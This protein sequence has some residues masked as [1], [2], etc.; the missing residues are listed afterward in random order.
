MRFA[1]LLLLTFA[2]ASVLV[3]NAFDPNSNMPA[4]FWLC[5]S[6]IYNGDSALHGPYDACVKKG[7]HF[8]GCLKDIEGF[9]KC[10]TF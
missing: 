5:I 9:A 3:V 7:E 1:I 10:F 4:T 8:V 2:L 6:N